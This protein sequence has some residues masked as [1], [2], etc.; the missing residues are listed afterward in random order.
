MFFSTSRN[1]FARTVLL[2]TITAMPLLVAT[3]HAQ[4]SDPKPAA[5]PSAA[6]PIV[7]PDGAEV[8][9][10]FAQPL[11]GKAARK[12]P[13]VP[14]GVHEAEAGDEVRLV[15]GTNV[16][17]DG[18]IVIAK[19]AVGKARVTDV[20]PV[21]S[22]GRTSDQTGIFLQ[23]EW[24][25]NV[26]DVEIPLR[27]FRKGKPEKFHTIVESDHGGVV[28]HPQKGLALFA[29]ASDTDK[30]V[31]VDP[32]RKSWIPPGSRLTAYV[33]GPVSLDRSAVD[34]AQAQLPVSASTA[35]LT[36][37][38]TQDNHQ[39]AAWVACDGSPLAR[40]GERQYAVVELAPGA[41]SF[42]IAGGKPL[43]VTTAPG[44]EYFLLVRPR[45][46][47]DWELKPV[48]TGEGEDSIAGAEM[49]TP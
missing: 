42:Q 47:G 48:S 39:S 32:K 31:P 15:A 34:Q 43:A 17:I 40:I 6:Q 33:Q 26:N 3:A 38:R 21:L 14:S 35:T 10:R 37:Y 46:F 16:R 12:N 28:V 18:H 25:K 19:G 1:F 2:G 49:V 5:A 44:E 20:L 36:I 22:D 45:T 7:I 23:L 30:D 13:F 24:I 8:E 41:H 9:L 4:R 29:V 27:A 11:M